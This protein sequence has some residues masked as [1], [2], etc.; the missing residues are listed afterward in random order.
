MEEEEGT[1]E[2]YHLI[3]I[4]LCMESDKKVLVI[5]G[6]RADVGL[7]GIIGIQKIA[8]IFCLICCIALLPQTAGASW[9][10]YKKR[11][12][13]YLFSPLFSAHSLP[14]HRAETER[15]TDSVLTRGKNAVFNPYAA[16]G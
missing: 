1:Y 10:P 5:S 2:F 12:Q 6:C 15:S 7:L 13:S 11:N 4:C 14:S 16:G 9:I 3:S 8:N